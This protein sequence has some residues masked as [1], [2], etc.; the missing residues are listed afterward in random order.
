M[1]LFSLGGFYPQLLWVI[2]GPST[3][4]CKLSRLKDRFGF[5]IKA[6]S[7]RAVGEEVIGSEE[8]VAR[9]I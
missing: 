5:V 2:G 3:Q 4:F 1:T 7:A 6:L 8:A 9:T